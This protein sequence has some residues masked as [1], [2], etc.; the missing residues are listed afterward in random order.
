MTAT[1]ALRQ[2]PAR[3]ISEATGANV[4]TVERWKA[5]S[6]PRRR[7]YRTRLDD[8]SATLE[9]L[10]DGLSARG[11]QAWLTARSAYL[12]WQRPIDL[13]AA[14]EFERVH[15]AALAYASGDPT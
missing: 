11:R 12:G 10:G 5:G 2:L 4:R 9:V 15:G 8:L 7:D 3:V 1:A 13:L 6:G 14:G